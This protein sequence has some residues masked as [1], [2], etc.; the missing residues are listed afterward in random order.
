MIRALESLH[1][2]SLVIYLIS[3]GGSAIVEKPIGDGISFDDLVQTYRV[4]VH[5]GAPIAR[6]N[7][8]RKHLSAVKGGRMAV[9]AS[10]AQQL[11]IMISDVPDNAHRFTGQ[12]ANHAGHQHD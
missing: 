12:R 5:S 10:P 2:R 9:A 1:E 4:L 8:V 3:G 6:I 7:A 11:S